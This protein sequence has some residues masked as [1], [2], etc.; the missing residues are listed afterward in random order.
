NGGGSDQGACLR[1]AQSRGL[2]GGRPRS[3]GG[4]CIGASQRRSAGGVRSAQRGRGGEN[5]ER[6]GGGGAGGGPRCRA[7]LSRALFAQARG[8][9][10]REPGG[11]ILRAG[12]L[13]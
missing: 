9:R 6:R 4:A 2:R 3:P 1:S 10:S 13:R 7:P 12:K 8:D 5:G 11:G